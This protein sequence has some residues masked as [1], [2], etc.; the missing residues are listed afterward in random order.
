MQHAVVD[1]PVTPGTQ[2]VVVAALRSSCSEKQKGH[3]VVGTDHTKWALFG[4]LSLASFFFGFGL[5]LLFSYWYL[6]LCPWF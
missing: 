3:A 6:V 5:C 2:V 4:T 1:T